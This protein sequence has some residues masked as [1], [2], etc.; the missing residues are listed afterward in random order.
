M[1]AVRKAVKPKLRKIEPSFYDPARD[2]V[3]QGLLQTFLTCREK[4]R[5]FL[6]GWSGDGESFS[7]L[8][9]GIAHHILRVAYS[10][11]KEG[12]LGG[13][14]STEWMERRMRELEKIWRRDHPTPRQREEDMF[15]DALMKNQAI[16]PEYFKYYRSD[17]D[18]THRHWLQVEES[19]SLPWSVVTRDDITLR[20]FLRGRIDGAYTLP[21]RKHADRP[22]LLETKT[23]SQFDEQ[24]LIDTMP[25]ERQLTTY[26]SVLRKK[27]GKEPIS[28]MLNIIRKPLLRQSK[29]ESWDQFATRIIRDVQLRPEFYFIRMEM[30]LEDQDINVAEAGLDDLIRDFLLWWAGES[31]HYKNTLSCRM[32]GRTCEFAKVCSHGDYTGL[33]KR[34]VI[35]REL[36]DE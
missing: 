36:E 5:L 1:V 13:P 7:L 14:P 16:M 35:F 25:Q 31:G 21:G 6:N 30:T 34:A 11:A 3:T 10:Q 4:T 12:K 18:P 2:G 28:A 20:T 8:Y 22:R 26:L 9:G 32:Y 24:E 23:R 15:H 19:F 29:K 27:T 33:K 17:F